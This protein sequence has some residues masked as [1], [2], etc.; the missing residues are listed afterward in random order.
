MEQILD[1]LS[2]GRA[3]QPAHNNWHSLRDYILT[4]RATDQFDA[5]RYIPKTS[6]DKEVLQLIPALIT[7]W[8]AHSKRIYRLSPEM[9]KQFSRIGFGNIRLSDILMPLNSF[10]VQLGTTLVDEAG[11]QCN[12]VLT[13]NLLRPSDSGE[14][15]PTINVLGLP[16]ST[17]RYSGLNPRDRDVLLSKIR[18]HGIHKGPDAQRLANQYAA[19]SKHISHVGNVSLPYEDDQ[20]IEDYFKQLRGKGLN[21]TDLVQAR[22]IFN[23]CLYLQSLPPSAEQEEGVTWNTE[24]VSM[25]P[26]SSPVITA[27]TEVC[28]IIGHH[29]LTSMIV[30]EKAKKSEQSHPTGYEVAPHWRRAH[31]RRP[32]GKGHIPDAERT[33]KVRHTLV[34]ADRIPEV[35]VIKGSETEV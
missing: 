4:F 27:R 21:D 3:Q 7:I 35:G 33:V 14:V 10:A 15:R 11:Y 31:L 1:L 19:M 23:L 29:I 34:R 26:G 16:Q 8:V 22:I 12:L 20:L 28:D 5:A 32:P 2:P 24:T 9:Q 17:I 18:K 13:T 25:A 6:P 30:E